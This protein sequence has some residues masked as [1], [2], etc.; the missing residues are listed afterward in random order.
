MDSLYQSAYLHP[1]TPPS[2]YECRPY[3][4]TTSYSPPRRSHS[5]TSSHS[6]SHSYGSSPDSVRTNLTTPIKS[7]IRHH[8]PILLPKI[9]PQDQ[10]VEPV[11]VS[12]KRMRR[13]PLSSTQNPPA[14]SSTM[15]GI[16]R[17]SS[18]SRSISN[19]VGMC[20]PLTSPVAPT[21]FHSRASST[22]CSPISLTSSRSASSTLADDHLLGKY[23]FPTYRQLPTYNGPSAFTPS[24][25]MH[26]M[27]SIYVPAPVARSPPLSRA[28]TLPSELQYELDGGYALNTTTTLLNYLTA[29]NPTPN[30]VRQISVSIGRSRDNGNTHFWWDIRNLRTWK[31][32]NMQ[33]IDRVPGLMKLLQIEVPE[34]ALPTPVLDKRSLRPETES[35]LNEL[36]RTFYAEKVNASLRLSQG[37]PHMF[38]KAGKPRT[39]KRQS[40]DFISNYAHDIDRTVFGD[41][42]GRVVGLVKSFNRWNTGMRAE[43]PH[44]Q[45]EYLQGLAHLHRHMREHGTRYGYIITE[46]ELVCV[47]ASTDSASNTPYF[48]FLELAPA[49]QLNVAGPDR[50][51]ACLA[52]WYLHMLAK[53]QPLPG[54]PGYKLDVG[55]PAALSRQNCWGDKDPW[56]PEPQLGEK[57]EARRVRGWVFPNEPLHRKEMPKRWHK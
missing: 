1:T 10:D 6:S 37:Q 35:N 50:L 36:C 3:V 16:S 29:P 34:T 47:R 56:I 20:A 51:T 55:A 23:G 48:G 4:T 41:G 27:P 42:K 19:P 18:H 2:S 53:E 13:G 25:S 28:R 30:L 26:D 7:P 52:L 39:E 31:D 8:G 22:L 17:R 32:F 5:R 46:I 45:V 14:A 12:P 9:R 57:R 11:L 40:P 54:Q 44:K 21:R 49:I 33:S 43:S 15:Y 38:M 24:S